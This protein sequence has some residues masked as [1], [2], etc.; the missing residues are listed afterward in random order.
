MPFACP[1]QAGSVGRVGYG[2]RRYPA[3]GH[4]ACGDA[5]FAETGRPDGR[6]LFLLVDV[7]DHGPKA[8]EVVDLLA[9]RI[10]PDRAC[11]D[12][13]PAPLLRTLHGMLQ[14]VWT[15]TE[16][17]VAALALLVDGRDGSLQGAGA[18]L[19][20]PRGRPATGPW[21]TCTLAGGIF[22]GAPAQGTYDQTGL[23]LEPGG[24]LLAFSDGVSE[25]K[26][27]GGVMYGRSLLGEHLNR[28]PGALAG[29]PLLDALVDDLRGDVG[30]GWPQDDTLLLCLW[31][32][33]GGGKT[34]EG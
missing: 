14:P 8:A 24:L 27:R 9:E 2:W 25:A 7:T 23:S 28:L 21:D 18:G 4:T 29:P 30:E 5:L 20:P 33:S 16:R 32:E 22:L 13:E 17:F 26:D 15:T 34:K 6:T 1:P 10:L 12:L 11:A 19:P 3:F 31:G